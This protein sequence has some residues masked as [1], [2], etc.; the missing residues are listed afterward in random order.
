MVSNLDFVGTY[1]WRD[2]LLGPAIIYK[3]KAS[4]ISEAATRRQEPGM[5]S[6]ED[7]YCVLLCILA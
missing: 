7:V 4:R 3:K 1:Y 5:Q 6:N 2:W